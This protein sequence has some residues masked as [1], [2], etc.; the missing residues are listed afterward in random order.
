[1]YQKGLQ[2]GQPDVAAAIGVVLVILVLVI[3]LL[4]NRFAGGRD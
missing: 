1:M 2:Q 3:A 4:Q